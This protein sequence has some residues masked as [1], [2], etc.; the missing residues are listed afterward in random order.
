[1]KQ[2]FITIIVFSILYFCDGESLSCSLPLISEQ[3]CLNENF[4]KLDEES[5][6]FRNLEAFVDSVSNSSENTLSF[7]LASHL[8]EVQNSLV[9]SE[10]FLC[11]EVSS[12]N[13]IDLY[14][15]SR[16]LEL[17]NIKL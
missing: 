10:K 8:L 1:M 13:V 17:K 11:L 6:D 4:V 9:E 15:F 12:E 5:V 14:V 2:N 7:C 3:N 16:N